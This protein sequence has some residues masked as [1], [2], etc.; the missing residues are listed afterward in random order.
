MKTAASGYANSPAMKEHEG[1]PSGDS[2]HGHS[3]QNT[4]PVIKTVVR[5]HHVQDRET[6]EKQTAGRHDH[7]NGIRVM[8]FFTLALALEVVIFVGMPW[9]LTVIA[10]LG[11]VLLILLEL[12]FVFVITHAEDARERHQYGNLVFIA[13]KRRR[14]PHHET[15]L[16][17]A[18]KRERYLYMGTL[19]GRYMHR[20]LKSVGPVGK[21]KIREL[22]GIISDAVYADGLVIDTRYGKDC[23]AVSCMGVDDVKE[24][25]IP[26]LGSNLDSTM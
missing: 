11:I 7:W 16:A 17:I 6:P 21:S 3:R 18:C 26:V 10:I 9:R 23:M 5:F 20:K 14:L 8:V 13:V 19:H 1:E 15:S 12:A 2:L 24:D 4:V 22:I 25:V